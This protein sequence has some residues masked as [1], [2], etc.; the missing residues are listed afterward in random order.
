MAS[1]GNNDEPG[2][3]EISPED[4]EAFKRRASDL[5]TRL[6]K[7][8][9]ETRA[10]EGPTPDAK[11]RGTALGQAMKIAIELVVGIA[12]GG[13]IGKVLDDWLGTAPWLMIVF[14][15]VGFAAGMTNTVRSARRMQADAL[16]NKDGR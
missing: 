2:R 13:F 10:K 5:G 1:S 14:V 4:R 8:R 15:L 3:G 12:V 9:A 16:R 6:E 11:S 7:V